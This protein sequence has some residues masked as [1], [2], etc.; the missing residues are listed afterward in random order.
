MIKVFYDGKCPLC[1]KEIS[2]YKTIAPPDI[3]DWLDVANKPKILNNFGI[4]RIT[5]LK[6]LHV[7]NSKGEIKIGV[8]AFATIWQQLAY[9]KILAWIIK[10]PIIYS[11]ASFM[12]NTFADYRFARLAHCSLEKADPLDKKPKNSNNF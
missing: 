4:D 2:Y 11:I 8:N 7:Q 3:F 10:L 1:N 12:Y 9:W 5:A 6:R